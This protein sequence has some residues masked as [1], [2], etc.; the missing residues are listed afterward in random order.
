MSNYRKKRSL[1]PI[2]AVV[3]IA[4]GIASAGGFLVYDIFF[5][6]AAEDE[7]AL[8]NPNM[9]EIGFFEYHGHSHLDV[10]RINVVVGGEIVLGFTAPVFIGGQLYL[11]ADI[12]RNY[13]DR[14]I[15]WEAN[16]N[17]LTITNVDEVLRFRPNEFYFTNN[18]QEVQL[19]TPIREVWGMAFVSAEMIMRMY[20]VNIVYHEEYGLVYIDFLRNEQLIYQVKTLSEEAL[21]W[22]AARFGP[23]DQYPIMA[24]LFE[25]D[26]VLFIEA[27]QNFGEEGESYFS[28][29]YRV[30]LENGLVG[31]VKSSGLAL[32]E[33]IAGVPEVPQHRPLTRAFDRPINLAYHLLGMNNPDSWFAPRGVNVLSPYW[34]RFVDTDM[35]NI[36]GDI[37][38]VARHDYVQWAHANGLEVWAMLT[39]N[40]NNTVARAVLLDANVRDHV[41]AQIMDLITTFNLDGININ[42]EAVR[43][44]EGEH[45]IQFLRELAVPMR[46]AGAVLSVTAFVPIPNYNM[47]W[48]RTEM[49]LTTDFVVIMAYDEHWRTSRTPGPVASFN[50]VANGVRRTLEEVPSYRI[51]VALPTYVNIWREEFVEGQ[52]RHADAAARQVG[53]TYA[54]NIITSMGGEFHWD[55][56]IRQ[57]FGEVEFVENG[58]EMRLRVWLEDLRSIEEKLTVFSRY[59]LAGVGFW[60]KYLAPPAMWDLVHDVLE[61]RD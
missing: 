26:R 13:V 16:T 59:D 20:P 28:G 23:S 60:Q 18:R 11:P 34:F 30:R 39:D 43:A 31:Y 52:W 3:V 40:H 46:Q 36:N 48:N 61:S 19:E 55:Y 33:E 15:F 7:A 10:G 21:E 5:R 45:W 6:R 51:I 27:R 4:L 9:D 50:F 44:P 24:R 57:Y 42:Y 49:G 53:M 35:D 56:I 47:F 37:E 29:F 12:L 2:I 32:V 58:V 14:H 22:E 38:S 25:G 1:A 54:H 8:L 41:I 17:R